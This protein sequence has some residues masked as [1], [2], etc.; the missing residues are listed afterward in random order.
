M[1]ISEEGLRLV[2]SFEGFHSKQPDGSCKAYRCPAGVW[3]CGWGCTEG[4]DAHTHWSEAEAKEHMH[5][6]L[7]KFN[8]AVLRHVR[9]PLNQN[10]FDAL[11]SFA[12]NLGEGALQKSSIVALLNREKR[13]AAAKAFHLYVKARDPKNGNKLRTLKG[14]VSRRARESALFLKPVEAPAE[15]YMPQS[16]VAEKT[17]A[18][19]VTEAVLGTA[20]ATGTAATVSPPVSVPSLP[21]PPKE[22]LETV[23]GWQTAAETLNNFAHSSAVWIAVCGILI[24]IVAPMIARR[25]A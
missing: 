2:T 3:T 8:A 15:P 16:V 12:Y 14:L 4:V 24:A 1:K 23:T 6:E 18:R 19:K 11:V 9:V 21:A 10:E 7:E 20:V 17:V 22:V 25:S 5:K 13:V